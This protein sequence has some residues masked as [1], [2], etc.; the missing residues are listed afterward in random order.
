MKYPKTAFFTAAV[1]ALSCSLLF[2]NKEQG[3]SPNKKTQDRSLIGGNS[4]LTYLADGSTLKKHVQNQWALEDI[5]ILQAWKHTKG[6]KDIV[7]AVIDTGIHTEH[8]CLKPNLWVNKGEIPNNN[9]DDDGNGF[10][11]D[12]HGW[13]FVR[14][15]NDIQDRH[16]HG[17]H[18]AGIIAATGRTQQNPKCKVIGVAPQVS[19]MT[20]KYYSEHNATKNVENTIKSIEYA[21]NQGA[22][23]INYSGG[24]PGS[25][26]RERAL[27]AKAA[28]REIIFV[29][30]S[31]ND[32][33]E[34]G[35]SVKYYPA[36]YGLPNIIYVQSKNSDNEIIDSSNWVRSDYREK[37][38]YQTAPGDR[39]ASTLPP[40]RYTQGNLLKN[41]WRTIASVE[42]EEDNYGYLTGTSQA[43]AVA[44]G[45]AALVKSRYP[46]WTMNQIINQIANTGFDQ[47]NEKIR[48]KTNEGKKLDAI[49][50]L[51]MRDRGVDI[52]DSPIDS[53]IIVPA[54]DQANTL[55][56][57]HHSRGKVDVYNPNEDSSGG[58]P[59]NL[60]QNINESLR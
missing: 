8:S 23:I 29:S 24:G 60:L 33:S 15:N 45:V 52:S 50:A 26:E 19:I 42:L 38:V 41:I 59:F 47:G 39:I 22:D 18:I 25:N 32:S 11:D 36:N 2:L 6:R 55:K 44:T 31:G 43:T 7:V 5:S 3:R 49:K 46:S 57:V 58:N 34:I 30:A 53:N 17:T 40:R 48:A 4:G 35:K 12:V 10:V 9:K 37:K 21:I 28:D 14:N 13:N 54:T 51:N 20:L 1:L 27:I 16:G 56:N